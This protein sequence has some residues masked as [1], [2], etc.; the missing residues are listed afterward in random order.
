MRSASAYRSPCFVVSAMLLG[1]CRGGGGVDDRSDR[2]QAR[3]EIRGSRAILAQ[4]RFADGEVFQHAVPVT[5]AES[6]HSPPGETMQRNAGDLV[7]G[8]LIPGLRGGI[9]I[10]VVA[11]MEVHPALHGMDVAE[12]LRVLDVTHECQSPMGRLPR[13]CV[14]AVGDVVG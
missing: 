10:S 12:F 6:A 1:A 4:D 7:D 14:V 11:A 2:P 13:L 5:E 8:V 3:G 9:D